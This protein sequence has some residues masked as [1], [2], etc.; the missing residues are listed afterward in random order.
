[1][2]TE[3]KIYS[4]DL[5]YYTEENVPEC[6]AKIFI[7]TTIDLTK[8]LKDVLKEDVDVQEAMY[9]N[10]CESIGTVE[11]VSLEE[12]EFYDNAELIYM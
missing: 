10:D 12:F 7:S 6:G 9:A 4:V 11:E 3:K 5:L 8:V 2:T 1:M